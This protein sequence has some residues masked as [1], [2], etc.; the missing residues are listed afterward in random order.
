MVAQFE[1][2][3]KADEERVESDAAAEALD[4]RDE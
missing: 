4:D 1:A 2:E 3:V